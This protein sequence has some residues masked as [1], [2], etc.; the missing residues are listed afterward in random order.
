VCGVFFV[1]FLCC[2][3]GFVLGGGALVWGW[4][5][6]VGCVFVVVGFCLGVGLGFFGFFVGVVFF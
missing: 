3:E 2:F 5:F 6:F 1:G 4:V